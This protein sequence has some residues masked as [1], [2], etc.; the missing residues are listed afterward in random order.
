M[1]LQNCCCITEVTTFESLEVDRSGQ[2]YL[3]ICGDNIKGEKIKPV[4]LKEAREWMKKNEPL[5]SWRSALVGRRDWMKS[6]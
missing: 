4:T 1:K 2:F 3:K 6:N 5:M